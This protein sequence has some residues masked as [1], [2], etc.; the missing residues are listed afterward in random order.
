MGGGIVLDRPQSTPTCLQ[1]GTAAQE[2]V[3]ARSAT[4]SN[5]A[6]RTHVRRAAGHE[7]VGNG[8]NSRR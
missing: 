6:A 4:R 2:C 1:T 3:T 8:A 7:R 5:V